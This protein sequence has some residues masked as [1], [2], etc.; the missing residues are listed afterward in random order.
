VDILGSAA[1]VLKSVPLRGRTAA[2][3]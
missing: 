2:H 3:Q 1:G